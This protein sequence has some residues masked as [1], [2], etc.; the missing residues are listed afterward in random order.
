MQPG[1]GGWGEREG[2][3]SKGQTHRQG[4]QDNQRG[5]GVKYMEH[6]VM[7]GQKRDA[8]YTVEKISVVK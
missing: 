3:G 8:R 4:G 7:N 2:R 5:G 1:G 6:G